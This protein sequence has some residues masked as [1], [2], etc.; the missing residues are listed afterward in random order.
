MSDSDNTS[1]NS[2]AQPQ[3]T[4][5]FHGSGGQTIITIPTG[6][7]NYIP[8]QYYTIVVGG[9][10]SATASEETA[11]LEKKKDS[12]GCSCKICKELYPYAEPNQEDGTLIC[13]SCRHGY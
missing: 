5:T 12:D 3:Q 2:N 8:G 9:G 7:A 13:W 1:N 10:G 11:P 4:F 6:S